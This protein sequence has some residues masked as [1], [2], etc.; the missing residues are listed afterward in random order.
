MAAPNREKRLTLRALGY[1]RDILR[2]RRFPR[3]DD[4][5]PGALGD[6]WLNCIILKLAAPLGESRFVHVGQNL[7]F[8]PRAVLRECRL[9]DVPREAVLHA[10][11]SYVSR[12][13]EKHVPVSVDGFT[14]LCGGFALYRSILMPL[15]DGGDTIDAVFGAASFREAPIKEQEFPA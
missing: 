11:T 8:P 12:V 4:V 15:S 7:C 2:D 6:D 13:L 10:A 14:V 9:S 1:W 3:C 5:D